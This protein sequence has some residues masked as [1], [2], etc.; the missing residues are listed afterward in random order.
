M[1]LLGRRLMWQRAR[2][3]TNDQQPASRLVISEH[4]LALISEYLGLAL[5]LEYLGLA[6][7]LEYLGLALISEYLGLALISEYLG[8][9]LIFECLGPRLTSPPGRETF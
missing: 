2:Q 7:I 3:Q 4:L 8:L 9:A 1:G 5:I 6:L